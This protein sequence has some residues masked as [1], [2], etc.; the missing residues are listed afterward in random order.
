MSQNDCNYS[1]Q[2]FS[3]T[4]CKSHSVS[5]AVM[6]SARSGFYTHHYTRVNCEKASCAAGMCFIFVRGH[7]VSA[8]SQRIAAL[9]QA[10]EIVRS[11]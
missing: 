8:P 10:Y 1:A 9:M 11:R 3:L 2:C 7:N 6:S 5:N 4:R